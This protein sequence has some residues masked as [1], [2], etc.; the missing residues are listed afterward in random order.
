MCDAL[1][2][3]CDPAPYL[4]DW[5]INLPEQMILFWNCTVPQV[6]SVVVLAA[7]LIL[8]KT[9]ICHMLTGLNIPEPKC[10]W[11]INWRWKTPGFAQAQ[12]IWTALCLRNYCLINSNSVSVHFYW[13]VGTCSK[14]AELLSSFWYIKRVSYIRLTVHDYY[15]KIAQSCHGEQS[16]CTRWIY[17]AYQ[18]VSIFVC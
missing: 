15:C 4:Y 14:T 16:T 9:F 7:I 2:R 17:G 1:F 6:K 8:F 3:L 10:H 5:V 11:L 18:S 12:T 13:N